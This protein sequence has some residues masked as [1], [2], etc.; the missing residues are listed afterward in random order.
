LTTTTATSTAFSST[1]LSTAE[2][3]TAASTTSAASLATTEFATATASSTEPGGLAAVLVQPLVIELDDLSLLLALT[4]TLGL[5]SGSG[6]VGV[7]LFAGDGLALREL[8]R[9]AL[10]G[11]ADVLGGE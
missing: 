7:L 5:A 2:L 8:L 4:L 6:H 9:A 1:K 3:S 10:V 11:L